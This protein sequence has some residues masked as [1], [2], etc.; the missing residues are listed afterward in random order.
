MLAKK[1]VQHS[2]QHHGRLAILCKPSCRFEQRMQI[3]PVVIAVCETDAC[4]SA[5]ECHPGLHLVPHPLPCPTIQTA[6]CPFHHDYTWTAVHFDI[7][8]ASQT[9]SLTMLFFH[10][11]IVEMA[12]ISSRVV[13][14]IEE[15]CSPKLVALGE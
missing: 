15:D 3:L 10:T 11:R 14:R 12:S 13:F 7:S 9:V 8:I 4:T 6:V 1:D 2:I 5:I